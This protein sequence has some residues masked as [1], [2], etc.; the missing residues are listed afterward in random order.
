MDELFSCRN[1]IQNC[2]QSLLIGRGAGYCVKHDTVLFYPERTTCKYLHRK[3]LPRFVVDE[4]LREHASEFG[5]FSGIADLLEHKPIERLHYSE[6]FAWERKQFDPKFTIG[7][8]R[9]CDIVLADDTVAVTWD[10]DH[11]PYGFS[12]GNDD[13]QAKDTGVRGFFMKPLVIGD[14]SEM[15]KKMLDE[16]KSSTQQ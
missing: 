12:N 8:S 15:V 11:F 2:G 16:S 4:G 10:S 3:D 6:K 9:K 13:Q 14:L 7:R 5:G 1:C